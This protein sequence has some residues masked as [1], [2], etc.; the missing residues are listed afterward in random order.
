MWVQIF[1]IFI[2]ISQVVIYKLEKHNPYQFLVF[3]NIM[4]PLLWFYVEK[5]KFQ[6]IHLLIVSLHVIQ[7]LFYVLSINDL[8]MT[9]VFSYQGLSVI[10]LQTLN[11]KFDSIRIIGDLILIYICCILFQFKISILFMILLPLMYSI[12]IYCYKYVEPFFTSALSFTT[13]FLINNLFYLYYSE[14]VWTG[15]IIISIAFYALV[16][17]LIQLIWSLMINEKS[18]LFVLILGQLRRLLV[19]LLDVL[20][21]GTKIRP[22]VFLLYGMTVFCYICSQL[23]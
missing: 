15:T 19:L 6:W 12:E 20:L 13:A 3:T 21:F 14:F 5:I 17:V 9:T 18:G 8:D 22:D 11:R 2:C 4:F 10:F 16:Q 7:N 1:Y 23:L